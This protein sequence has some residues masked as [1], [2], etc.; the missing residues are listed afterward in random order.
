[1]AVQRT[2]C[3]NRATVVTPTEVLPDTDLTV[4]GSQIAQPEEA[5]GPSTDLRGYLVFPALINAH[6]HLGG[7]WWPRVGPS[8][9]YPSVYPWLDELHVSPVRE[10]RQLNSAAD[11]YELGM[12][13]CLFSGV[14][15]VADHL[16]RIDGAEF[17]E[18]FPIEVL[19]KYGRTWTVREPTAWGDDIQT[20]YT[21]AVRTGQPYV[22][23]L[24]EGLDSG[25]AQEMDYLLAAGA[26]GRNTLIVHGIGLRPPDI[27]AMAAVGASLCWC[28]GSNLYLY[29]QTADLPVLTHAGL[30]ITLGTDSSLSGELNLLQEL[31]TARRHLEERADQLSLGGRS[32]EQWLVEAVTRRAARALLREERCGRIAPGYRADL[33]VL[34]DHGLDPYT[35]LIEAQMGDIAL[36]CRAGV[37]VYGD[38]CFES[39]FEQYSP[40][41]SRVQMCDPASN[42]SIQPQT[43]LVAGD[44]VALLERMSET[45]GHALDLPFLPLITNEEQHQCPVS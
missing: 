10:E 41:Y 5:T 40:D 29:E 44:P 42:P 9:P 32:I 35:A 31:K 26:L 18:R 24:A 22:I 7:T 28:P 21:R 17:Y 4:A 2:F 38:T 6:D 11:V 30:N 8:R 1:M 20:E 34:A 43:K 45:V 13:R 12:Y 16:W 33:L 27:Q 3:L 37:P 25:T 23:H 36:L 19:Y 15:T 39:L 14:S